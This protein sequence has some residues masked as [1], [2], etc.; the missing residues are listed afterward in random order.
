V[1]ELANKEAFD[2]K[3]KGEYKIKTA[4]LELFVKAVPRVPRKLIRTV[5]LFQLQKEILKDRGCHAIDELTLARL[6]ILQLLAPDIYR[7]GRQQQGFL[8]MLEYW[9][10]HETLGKGKW[11]LESSKHSDFYAK[12]NEEQSIFEIYGRPLLQKIRNISHSRSGFNIRNIINLEYPSASPLV[13]YFSAVDETNNAKVFELEDIT[14]LMLEDENEFIKLITSKRPDAWTTVAGL[15]GINNGIMHE[16]LFNKFKALV[17]APITI[18]SEYLSPQW[19]SL[20]HPMIAKQYAVELWG[21]GE[22]GLVE[23]LIKHL[24]EE[25]EKD[26]KK[27]L[28]Y[29]DCLAVLGDTRKGVGVIMND[30]GKALPDI[31]W[32]RVAQ[33]EFIFG[34]DYEKNNKEKMYLDAFEISRYPITNQQFQCFLDADDKD[35]PEWW[36]D[37]P[38]DQLEELIPSNRS[39]ANRPK[40][41]VSWYQAVAFTRWL[42]DKTGKNI[43]LPTEFEWEKAARGTDGRDYPWGN[44]KPDS[45]KLNYNGN[46]KETSTVGLYTQGISPCGA[47]DMSGNVWEWCLNKYQ[48][49]ADIDIDDGGAAREIRGGSYDDSSDVV[50]CAVRNGLLPVNRGSDIGFRLV[51]E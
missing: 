30:E 22:N 25:Y 44:E 49:P 41:N 18:D 48:S 33:G 5:E 4:L 34:S 51:C 13:P 28:H 23:T 31:K 29:G 24:R 1:H 10:K 8:G 21:E 26:P 50:R 3:L 40:E 46:I 19:L 32:Q 6:V 45:N 43:R 47:Y 2:Y 35:K 38:E 16:T 39:Q 17:N 9:E 42:S 12:D 36:K 20:V 14:L 37:M 11:L 7:F 15:S 27:R